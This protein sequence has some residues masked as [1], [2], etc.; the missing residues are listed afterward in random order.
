MKRNSNGSDAGTSPAQPAGGPPR[1]DGE[2]AVSAWDQGP[3]VR[4]PAGG[5]DVGGRWRHASLRRTSS[6]GGAGHAGETSRR[7][8][9]SLAR[10]RRRAR[11]T[12]PGGSGA[13]R[14]PRPAAPNR[15]SPRNCCEARRSRGE[16][17]GDRDRDRIQDRQN[18]RIDRSHRLG[19]NR[20]APR[21]HPGMPWEAAVHPTRRITGAPEPARRSPCSRA[22]TTG[23][24]A[25]LSAKG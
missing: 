21:R 14:A 8:D 13:W 5:D 9:D 24:D 4:Y 15:A 16:R 10:P 20:A 17:G 7:C 6:A 1:S 23:C 19:K 18:L 2:G 22:D 25:V 11:G 3:I 12:D